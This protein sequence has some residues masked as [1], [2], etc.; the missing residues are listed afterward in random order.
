MSARGFARV[1]R[2]GNLVASQGVVG[3][4]NAVHLSVTG[5][6]EGPVTLGASCFKLDFTPVTVIATSIAHA[7]ETQFGPILYTA[8]PNISGP[9]ATDNNG[10]PIGCPAGFQDAAVVG[11]VTAGDGLRF[12][13]GGFFVIFD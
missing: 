9:L 7:E 11:R 5:T 2:F 12:P 1:D 10:K 3:I 6:E 4:K 13:Q 8:G